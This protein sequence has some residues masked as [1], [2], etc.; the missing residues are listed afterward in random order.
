VS[1]SL[2]FEDFCKSSIPIQ[3]ESTLENV[4][5][6]IMNE[7]RKKKVKAGFPLGFG[8]KDIICSKLN[9]KEKAFFIK[10]VESLREDGLIK[11]S[12]DDIVNADIILTEKGENSIY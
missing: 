3:E 7:F 5:A 11:T 2:K 1:K 10:A 4:K 8:E 12:N 9:P 6:I